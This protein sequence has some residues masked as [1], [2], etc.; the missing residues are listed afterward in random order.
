[1]GPAS[2]HC[3]STVLR[4]G[5]YRRESLLS[6]VDAWYADA[7]NFLDIYQDAHPDKPSASPAYP[8]SLPPLNF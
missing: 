1:M 5:R 7:K 4:V 2:C 3:L 8:P 6:Y